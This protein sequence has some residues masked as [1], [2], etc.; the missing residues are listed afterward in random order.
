MQNVVIPAFGLMP[1]CVGVDW[2]RIDTCGML[3]AVK[4]S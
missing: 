2:M 1:I 4:L 3:G